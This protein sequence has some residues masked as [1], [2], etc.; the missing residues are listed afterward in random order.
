MTVMKGMLTEVVGGS[1]GCLGLAGGGL[2]CQ[3]D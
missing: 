1:L 3:C 2:S